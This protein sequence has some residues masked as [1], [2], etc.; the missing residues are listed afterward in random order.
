M[1]RYISCFS[2]LLFKT[3]RW[4]TWKGEGAD[5]PDLR[6]AGECQAGGRARGRADTAAQVHPLGPRGAEEVSPLPAACPPALVVPG[7]GGSLN[8]QLPV[9]TLLLNKKY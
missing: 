5:V 1:C 8:A 9:T 6:R 3:R 4:Q 7:E 2:V